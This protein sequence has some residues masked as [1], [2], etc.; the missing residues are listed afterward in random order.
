MR[1][2]F[3]WIA[4]RVVAVVLVVACLAPVMALAAVP[5]TVTPMASGHLNSSNAYIYPVG[6]GDVRIYFTAVADYYVED[7]GALCIAVYESTNGGST[8]SHVKTFRHS[9]YATM[10]AHNVPR[11]V[12]YVTYY[13]TAGNYYKANVSIWAGDVDDNGDVRYIW[14]APEKAT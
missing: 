13:G 12:S 3:W 4:R 9:D 2:R 10:L 14:T 5:E 8:W 7:I 1:K 11:Y 6:G